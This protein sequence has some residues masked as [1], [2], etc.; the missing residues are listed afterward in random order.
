MRWQPSFAHGSKPADVIAASAIIE[1]RG[2]TTI[3]DIVHGYGGGYL[4]PIL[5]SKS[6]T[7]GAHPVPAEAFQKDMVLVIQP[8][9]VTPDK[10][11]GVQ[12]GEMVRVTE[13]GIER[14]HGSTAW[15]RPD[16]H[17]TETFEHEPAPYHDLC[18]LPPLTLG[19][20]LA[21]Q[22]PSNAV[23]ERRG[24]GVDQELHPCTPFPPQD[25]TRP[26]TRGVVA[27][28]KVGNKI[29]FYDPTTLAKRPRSS[30]GPSL[31]CT[32]SR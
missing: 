1:E 4:S 27:V 24:E 22:A 9:V 31:A 18:L 5:S 29:R 7:D 20:V 8:N 28:D 32:N 12:T 21:G 23:R 2:F 3:D 30:M 26:V 25:R 13:T 10:R 6:R 15:V 16:R 17:R 14:M 19:S 11:A